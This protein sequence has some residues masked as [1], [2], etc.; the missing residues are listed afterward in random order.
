MTEGLIPI[1][2]PYEPFVDSKEKTYNAMLEILECL[3]HFIQY[4][5]QYDDDQIRGYLRQAE[6]CIER[7]KNF[8]EVTH[9]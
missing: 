1:K 2:S 8:K 3:V 7:G 4:P 6:W 9:D 5:R